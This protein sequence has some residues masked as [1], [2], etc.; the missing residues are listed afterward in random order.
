[1]PGMS[2]AL[3]IGGG[4]FLTNCFW[5]ALISPFCLVAGYQKLGISLFV[6]SVSQ[7]FL[8]YS[9]HSSGFSDQ[10]EI[11]FLDAVLYTIAMVVMVALVKAIS[12][13]VLMWRQ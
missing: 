1:M 5:I 6:V 3:V 12:M 4:D 13:K 11:F 8:Y 10:Q 7:L 9:L 2:L